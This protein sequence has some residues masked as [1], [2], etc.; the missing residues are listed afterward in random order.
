MSNSI[1]FPNLLFISYGYFPYNL[2]IP[3]KSTDYTVSWSVIMIRIRIAYICELFHSKNHLGFTIVF[4][5][6][7]TMVVIIIFHLRSLTVFESIS[8]VTM[9]DKH[10]HFSSTLPFTIHFILRTGSTALWLSRAS[11]TNLQCSRCS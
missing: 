2:F 7:F 9:S 1:C 11:T 8:V 3:L 4:A 5:L 6:F 10:E